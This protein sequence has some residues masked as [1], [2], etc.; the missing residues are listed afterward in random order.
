MSEVSMTDSAGHK[1]AFTI[2]EFCQCYGVGRSLVYEEMKAGRL[3]ARKAGGRTLVLAEDATAWA[4]SLPE[5]RMS[6]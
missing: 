1:A 5:A 3:R 6:A 4:Q 2:K